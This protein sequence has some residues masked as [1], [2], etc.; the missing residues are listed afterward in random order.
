VAELAALIPALDCE[1]TIQAV[2]QETRRFVP[3]VWVVDDGSSDRTADAAKAAG[4]EV[5]RQPSNRGKGAALRAG[6]QALL[7]DG[8]THVVTLDGDGQHLPEDIPRLL[9]A[10]A[11]ELDALVMGARQHE[12]G[13]LTKIR[14]FGNRYANRWVRIACGREFEDT[15]SGFRVYP[16]AATLALGCR[17]DRFAF[18]TEVVIRAVRAGLPV[19]SVPVRVYNPPPDQ[20]ISHFHGVWDSIRIVFT[21][22]GL[23]LRIR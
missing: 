21:V 15:Q 20:R 23:L 5:L 17:A 12:P 7:R 3:R 1:A 6:M 10:S 19:R 16:V 22:I 4:A 8:V 13:S 14:A 2:V 11:A 9:A 18:E